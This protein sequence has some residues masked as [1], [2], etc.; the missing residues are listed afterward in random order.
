MWTVKVGKNNKR[1][2]GWMK[3]MREMSKVVKEQEGTA[4]VG[5]AIGNT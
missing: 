1:Q 5:R 4:K 2:L 3:S